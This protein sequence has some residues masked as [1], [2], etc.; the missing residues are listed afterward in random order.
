MIPE[1]YGPI[2]TE[3]KKKKGNVFYENSTGF[4]VNAKLVLTTGLHFQK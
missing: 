3:M 4:H 2:F 1:N